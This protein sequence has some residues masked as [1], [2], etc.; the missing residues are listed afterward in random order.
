[1]LGLGVVIHE[2][3]AFT[4]LEIDAVFL[5]PIAGHTVVGFLITL[6]SEGVLPVLELLVGL[7]S[8][9]VLRRGGTDEKNGN[10]Q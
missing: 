9:A 1:M 5:G 10:N 7:G 4:H 2:A 3:V 6:K 8:D